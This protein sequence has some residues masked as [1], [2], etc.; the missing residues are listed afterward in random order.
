MTILYDPVFF[1]IPALGPSELM[2]VCNHHSNVLLISKIVPGWIGREWDL[3]CDNSTNDVS[4]CMTTTHLLNSNLNP[5][6]RIRIIDKDYKAS[7]FGDSCTRFASFFDGYDVFF[8][9]AYRIPRR[10]RSSK[11]ITFLLIPFVTSCFLQSITLS[12]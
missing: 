3:L 4:H 10:L 7:D 9:D 11:T 5:F 8:S 2:K 6:S 1:H 12:L